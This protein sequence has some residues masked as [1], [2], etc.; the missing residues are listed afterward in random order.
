MADGCDILPR[1]K[2][3]GKRFFTLNPDDLFPVSQAGGNISW[4]HD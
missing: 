1:P 4:A 2:R 3:A